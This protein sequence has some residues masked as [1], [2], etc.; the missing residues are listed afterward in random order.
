MLSEQKFLAVF[1]AVLLLLFGAALA[2]G[3]Y[4]DLSELEIE[5]TKAEAMSKAAD[6]GVD[7]RVL[8]RE[9]GK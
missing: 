1:F 8:L 6:A 7:L 9:E 4:I 5:R 3:I 2:F